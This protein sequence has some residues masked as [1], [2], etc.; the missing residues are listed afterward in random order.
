[1]NQALET[2]GIVLWESIVVQREAL[3]HTVH[4]EPENLEARTKGFHLLLR[5]VSEKEY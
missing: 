1:M 2:V 4:H 5:H 3:T